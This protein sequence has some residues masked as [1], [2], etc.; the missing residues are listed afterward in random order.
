[1][2]GLKEKLLAALREG[3]RTVILPEDVRPQVKEL[4]KDLTRDFEIVYVTEF[5]DVLPHVLA[6]APDMAGG[7]AAGAGLPPGSSPTTLN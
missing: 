4:R 1:V 3:V 2:G 6:A 5:P 7:P